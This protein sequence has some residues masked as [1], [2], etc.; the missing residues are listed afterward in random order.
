MSSYK[1]RKNK[2]YIVML[3]TSPSTMG[4]ISSVV[5]V[6][7][8]AGLF[9]RFPII[10]IATHSDGS[11]LMKLRFFITS[12]FAYLFLLL[13]GKIALIHVHSASRNSF[14]RKYFFLYPAFIFRVP[15]IF[16]LHGA[17]FNIFYDNSNKVMQ[18]LICYTLNK[19][20]SIVVLS[21]SWKHWIQNISTNTRIFSIY[22]PV[23]SMPASDF[24]LRD[25]MSV[26]F[27]GRLS[28]RKGVYD[29]L[30]AASHIIDKHP[31][32]KLILG[33]DGEL[34]IVREQANKLGIGANVEILGWVTG[35]DKSV[36]LE[37]AAIYVLPSYAEGLPM[38]VLEAMAV[39]LP[40]ISTP[41]GGIPEAVT[42]GL[43]GCLIQPGDVDALSK[44]LDRLLS[45]KDL[46]QRMGEAAR[47]KVECCF[48]A[49]HVLPQIERLYQEHSV[50]G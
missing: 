10:Y 33:G 46:R 38:S 21:H 9:D 49:G 25:S 29:L 7:Q 50:R 18:A 35:V 15:S 8:E 24:T 45:D 28:K 34:D 13:R 17:E 3:G 14:W 30:L 1:D 37:R 4:G 6:Y 31:N 32:L 19:V 22:N 16:H 48:S 26:L 47:I 39:G 23:S 36:L 5:N 20:D 41:V 44:A 12:W 2:K 11:K 40:V 27:L 43:E 42:D